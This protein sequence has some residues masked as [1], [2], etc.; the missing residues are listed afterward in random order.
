M[1]RA[2]RSAETRDDMAWRHVSLVEVAAIDRTAANPDKI[3]GRELYV[4]LENI[5][6]SG[7]FERVATAGKAGLKSMK[8][9]FTEVHVLY[10][11]LRPY[12][13]KIAAPN[14]EG[15]CSTDILPIRPSA[16][17]DR[18][19]LLHYLRTPRMVAHAASKAVGINLPR[20]NP[21]ILESFEVPLPPI[22]EQRRIARV[23]DAADALRVKRR[24]ALAKLDLLTQAI[25]ID[26]F[27]RK[28]Y[29][30]VPLANLAEFR[31]GTS[32]KAATIGSATLRIPNVVGGEISYED[33]TRVPVARKEITR[34]RLRD[35]DLL[36]VRSNGNPDYVG[37]CAAF[38]QQEADRA[39]FTEPVIFASYLIR[40]RMRQDQLHT[41]FA[42]TFL[43]G[44]SGRRALRT[45]CKTSA[46]Q[47]NLNTKGLGSVLL[48]MAPLALQHEFSNRTMQVRR[49]VAVCHDQLDHLDK[50]FASL[51]QRAFR[52]EL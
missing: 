13:A 1:T 52:G 26:M 6:S 8:F 37:R 15:I 12:L 45:R 16:C 18:R 14:F 38:S 32:E 3:S 27:D 17:L 44:P 31:Y 7:E 9:A 42:S 10:G 20:L 46:G 47:Y 4:G 19:Y 25:F 51:Q 35:G 39:G 5:T 2:S 49:R 41:I 29:D 24:Q 34:L 43:N 36:F 48:P 40:A 23:L 50:L 11:K 22:Q 33:I 28:S 21:K 30:L